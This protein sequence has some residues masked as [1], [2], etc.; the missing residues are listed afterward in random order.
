MKI[1]I[2][3]AFVLLLSVTSCIKKQVEGVQVLGV[4]AYEK[5]MTQPEVQLLDVRTA[6]EF[7]S[8]HLENAVNINIMGDDFD[9]QVAS[10]DKTK[11]V[12]VYCKAG[13]RSAKAAERLK[14]L[15]FTTITDLE[16]GISN[17]NSENKPVVTK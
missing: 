2:L 11:P 15:G 12:M 14:L 16:G 13:G 6:E 4:A 8:G 7:S 1:R 3:S 5:Q 10:L 9:A 17:W